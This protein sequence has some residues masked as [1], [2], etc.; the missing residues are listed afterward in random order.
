MALDSAIEQGKVRS[1]NLVV[2]VGSGVGYTRQGCAFR[3][4]RLETSWA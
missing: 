3:M 2:L 1:G 4:R